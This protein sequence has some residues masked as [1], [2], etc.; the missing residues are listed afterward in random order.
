MYKRIKVERYAI[1]M[2]C[3]RCSHAWNY[4][5]KNEYVAT[6]PLCRTKLSEKKDESELLILKTQTPSSQLSFQGDRTETKKE[7]VD[8]KLDYYFNPFLAGMAMWQG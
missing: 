3:E 7:H 5:G 2:V 8:S 6:C 4:I 1:P